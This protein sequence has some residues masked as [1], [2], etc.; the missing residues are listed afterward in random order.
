M[1]AGARLVGDVKA[2]GK[3]QVGSDARIDGAAHA[4]GGV[5]WHASARA[6]RLTTDG[7]FRI[8]EHVVAGSLEARRGVAPADEGADRG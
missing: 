8:G 5:A 6:A 7:P 4:D 2:T 3:L 1:R